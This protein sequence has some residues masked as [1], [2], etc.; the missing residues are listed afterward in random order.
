MIAWRV[1]GSKRP[2]LEQARAS[3]LRAAALNDLDR[4]QEAAPLLRKAIAQAE[5]SEHGQSRL[6]ASAQI[7][8]ADG[9]VLQL[10]GAD[11]M[12]IRAQGP[13]AVSAAAEAM[14]LHKTAFATLNSSGGIDTIAAAGA[15]A[16][17]TFLYAGNGMVGY[18]EADAAYAN[19]L[20][21]VD[22]LGVRLPKLIR[23]L[24][25]QVDSRLLESAAV[26]SL[27]RNCFGGSPPRAS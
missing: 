15:L 19:S 1:M 10:T 18:A 12:R 21:T 2:L 22:A 23:K 3:L 4:F 11:V 13:A 24:P 20:A 14:Q 5:A 17:A 26:V 25:C 7:K 8:L 6:A 27:G 9:L 16:Y